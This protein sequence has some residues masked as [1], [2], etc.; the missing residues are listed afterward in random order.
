MPSPFE[1]L[2]LEQ[3]QK[4]IESRAPSEGAKEARDFYAGEMWRD[5]EGWIGQRP[6]ASS[7]QYQ[8]QMDAIAAAQVGE[9]VIAEVIGRHR[10]GVLGREPRWGFVP[11]RDIPDGEEPTAEEQ[12]LMGEADA[13]LT[14]WWDRRKPLKA[15]Q[16]ALATA[17]LAER[18]PLRLFVPAGLRGEDGTIP[19][20]VAAADAEGNPRL[21][22]ALDLL[23]LD[24]PAPETAGVFTD[25]ATRREAGLFGFSRYKD[26]I[27]GLPPEGQGEACA[28]LSFVGD[29]GATIIRVIGKESIEDSDPL[30]LGGRLPLYDLAREALITPQVRQGQKAINLALTQM[31][32][33]VNLAGS[34]ERIFI[35][36]APPGRVVNKRT[37]EPWKKGDPEAD[38][39]FVGE[40]L[41][42]GA[43]VSAF[44]K[45]AEIRD[46]QDNL[47]GYANA[48]VNYR[49]PVPVDTFTA[50]RQEFRAAI[51]DQVAQ[52]HALITGD[53]MASAVSRK[54]ARAEFEASLELTKTALD[55][56]GRWL[57]ETLLA[58]AAIFAGQAGRYDSL[59]CEFG[60]TIDAGPLSADDRQQIVAEYQAE[61]LSRETTLSRL[62]VDDVE[63]EIA[64]I[65]AEGTARD[66]RTLS[67][68]GA[69]RPAQQDDNDPVNA[70]D[71]ELSE[72]A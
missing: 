40:A 29:E 72:V 45:G 42:V 48:T 35:N 56:A 53:A 6:P 44:L 1:T 46:K 18:A 24:T 65:E 39:Q 62:D 49:D 63:A 13:A 17:L 55:D 9:N 54:Q 5:G 23:F 71:D 26:G 22:A 51:L 59:R 4:L 28:E 36:A 50:T 66:E 11:R 21:A 38:R 3:S 70:L 19:A 61:L 14:G 33:N 58:L 32:R 57:L 15:L 31:V 2:T 43:G 41:P 37:G 25:D 10:A 20:P 69:G 12:A 34:L 7:P 52:K 16:S 47:T 68:V 67:V 8:A 64:R 30:P 27:P 60:A